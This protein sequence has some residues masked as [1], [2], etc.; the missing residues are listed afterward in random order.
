MYKYKTVILDFEKVHRLASELVASNIDHI[1][2]V[3]GIQNSFLDIY[4]L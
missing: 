1:Y 3:N 4:E 2:E